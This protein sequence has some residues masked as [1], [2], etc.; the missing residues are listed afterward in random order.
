[1]WQQKKSFELPR[2]VV[3]L[4]TR[5][6]IFSTRPPYPDCAPARIPQI[7]MRAKFSDKRKNNLFRAGPKAAESLKI[8]RILHKIVFFYMFDEIV[9]PTRQYGTSKKSTKICI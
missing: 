3:R 2:F 5:S 9:L 8:I 1:M 6:R 7:P 4:E